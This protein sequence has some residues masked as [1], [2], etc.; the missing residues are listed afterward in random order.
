MVHAIATP[1]LSAN[2]VT[3]YTTASTLYIASA[4]STS[5][6]TTITN[7][8]ALYV[9]SGNAYFGGNVVTPNRPAYR[10]AGSASTTY[11]VGTVIGSS[12]TTFTVDYNQGS[13]FSTSTGVFTAPVAGIYHAVGT[14]RVGT[15]NGLNQAAVVKTLAGTTT[16]SIQAFWETDT[17][18]GV[19]T[20]FPI[21]GY[22]KLAAGDTLQL[23]VVTGG[24]EFDSNDSFGITFIG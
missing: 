20:H 6:N 3:T 7:P 13:Y 18:T 12:A 24:V 4:P 15:N 1:T 9:N 17:N 5:T 2:N 16:T 14:L 19:A 8:Y 21:S 23:K 22:C 10:I 11:T